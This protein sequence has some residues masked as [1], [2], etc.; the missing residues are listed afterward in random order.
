MSD[1]QDDDR[2]YTVVINHEEQHSIWFVGREIPKGW[3]EVGKTGK[4]KECLDYIEENWKD[5][6]PLSVRK[7]LETLK[8]ESN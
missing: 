2:D 5:I 8:T 3:S 4:K 1:D 6:T 7:H